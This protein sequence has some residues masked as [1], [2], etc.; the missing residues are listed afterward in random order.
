M[1]KIAVIVLLSLVFGMVQ[2]AFAA[3]VDCGGIT[4]IIVLDG[5]GVAAT[6]ATGGLALI[7]IA[8][9]FLADGCGCSK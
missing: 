7:P 4:V 9:F 8:L 1:R 2:P 6:A 3:D 5:V